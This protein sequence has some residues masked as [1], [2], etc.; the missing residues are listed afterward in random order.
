MSIILLTFW[1]LGVTPKRLPARHGTS[2]PGSGSCRSS[3]RA[4]GKHKLGSFSEQG[5]R[6]LR[7][8]FTVGALAVIRYAEID[9][10]KDRPWLTALLARRPPVAAVA[11][12]N[13]LARMAWD[14]GS[15]RS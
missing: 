8:L 9:G 7:S 10:T 14:D 5:D 4:G 11:L 1:A 15:G 12:A 13:K 3:T 2:Q 6:Y